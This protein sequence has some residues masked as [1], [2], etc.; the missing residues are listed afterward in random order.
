MKR[1]A[2]VFFTTVLVLSVSGVAGAIPYTWEDTYAPENAPI[3]FAGPHRSGAVQSYS[4]VHDIT[5]D[6][7][8]PAGIFGLDPDVDDFV[9]A[10]ELELTLRD[11]AGPNSR[12]GRDVGRRD[13][14]VLVSLGFF[15][16]TIGSYE[17]DYADINTGWTLVGVIQLNLLGELSVTLDR[18]GGD[19]YFMQSH[20]KAH[21]N[22][23]SPAP[24]PEPATMLLL[25]TGLAGMAAAGRRR[26]AK[27]A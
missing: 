18:D 19:F 5:D 6:G 16:I 23:A 25:G 22:E 10:V 24:V 21:G 7:F 2:I 14:D 17:V 11:D 3:L 15:D 26:K 12:D 27:K 8:T 20:L 9:T 4:F 13:E 1:F